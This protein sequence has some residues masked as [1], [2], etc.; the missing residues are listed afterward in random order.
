M[1]QTFLIEFGIVLVVAAGIGIIIRLLRQPLILAYLIAGVLIGPFAFGIINNTSV[2]ENFASIGI[3]FLLFLIGLELNPRRLLEI[4]G[5]A[6]TIGLAQIAISGL[7]YY[8]IANIF[9]ITGTGAIYLAAAL[10]FS[11]TAIIVTLLSNRRDLDSLHGKLIVGVLLVQ[12]FVAIILLS[13][14]SGFSNSIIGNLLSFQMSFQIVLRAIILFVITFLI[15]QYVLPPTFHRIARSQELLFL[16]SLAWCFLLAITALALGFSAEIGAF[17]AGISLAPL[18]Y[19]PHIAAKT[20]P[21]R[22]FFIMIFFIYLGSNLV[23]SNFDGMIVPAFIFSALILFI[24]PMV[25]MLT[26]SI[27]GYSRR[28]SFITGITLTQTS[29]FSF[30][31]I[32]LGV[33]LNI[34][35]SSMTTLA[36]MIALITVFISTYL[37]ANTNRIYHIISPSLHFLGRGKKDDDIHIEEGTLKEHVVLIGWHRIGTIV[38]ETLKNE[39]QN[40]VVIDVDPRKIQKLT[41]MK[42]NC[43]FGD[44]AD[45]DIIEHI[46]LEKAKMVIS[47][48]NRTEE[49]DLI[50]R[51]YRKINKNLKVIMTAGDVDEAAELYRLGADLVIIPTMISGDYIAHILEQVHNGA[52][53]SKIKR[54]NLRHLEQYNDEIF[55]REEL[56]D[57]KKA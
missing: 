2:I 26:T 6:I 29:E 47:T 36:S 21:L 34:L 24:N 23:F 56:R 28:T 16:S 54:D 11:S 17:L 42:E 9:N 49:N 31:V 5:S 44:A 35:D 45:H 25:V 13:I 41:E 4:G 43:I 27:L 18:P 40:V 50:L 46:S 57:T 19:S 32:V 52:A 37:I 15:G 30:I 55:A 22:D 8:L 38:F 7:I 39:G 14:F 12:D 33:K 20:K 51:T 3:V 10:T 1:D 53:L 48:I